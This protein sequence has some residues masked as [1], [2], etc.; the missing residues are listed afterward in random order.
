[1][2]GKTRERKALE[3]VRDILMEACEQDGQ[4]FNTTEKARRKAYRAGINR[5]VAVISEHV[6][7][8]V[9]AGR[10]SRPAGTKSKA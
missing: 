4:D 10:A 1:M 3:R 6:P 2:A 8:S 9:P 7:S 5:A